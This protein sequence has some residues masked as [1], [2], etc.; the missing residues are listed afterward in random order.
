MPEYCDCQDYCDCV[1]YCENCN[2]GM[3]CDFAHYDDCNYRC[4]FCRK[5]Q[6]SETN[7]INRTLFFD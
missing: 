6:Y 1:C 7:Q 5:E 3:S 2:N 4:E